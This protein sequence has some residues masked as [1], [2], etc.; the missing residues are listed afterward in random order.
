MAADEQFDRA[1]RPT[2]PDDAQDPPRFGQILETTK[3][4]FVLELR[5]FFGQVQPTGRI[6]ELPTIEK[7]QVSEGSEFDPFLTG[8]EIVQEYP[9]ILEHLPHIAVTAAGGQNQRMTVGVPFI[10][11]VQY[12][13]EVTGSATGP[14]DLSTAPSAQEF[15]LRYRTQPFRNGE[16]VTSETI[17]RQSRFADWTTATAA[18]VVRV[19][20]EQALYACARLSPEGFIVIEAGGLRGRT[21]PNTIEIL[22][23]STPGILTLLGFSAGQQDNSFNTARP[24]RHRYHMAS[25]LNINIDVLASDVNVRRELADLVYSWATF[26]L[27]RQFFEF[28]GRSTHDRTVTPEEWYQIIFHQETS[29]AGHQDNQRLQD[30]KDKV[31]MQRV[32]VPVT[33]IQ[34]IDRAVRQTDGSNWIANTDTCRNDTTLPPRS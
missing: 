28:Q 18:D 16:W 8:V 7:Y 6:A 14:F 5:N 33:T 27:A 31:H 12:P 25:S 19:I 30:G 20:N 22:G 13:P 3:D 21:R 32:T 26:W 10:A 11:T 15:T 1:F 17:L 34:Y 23:S 24:P 9:D 2:V 29:V 4:A